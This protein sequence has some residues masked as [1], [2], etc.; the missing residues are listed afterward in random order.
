LD[1]EPFD[2]NWPEWWTIPGINM[3]LAEECKTLKKL[4]NSGE[5]EMELRALCAQQL[6]NSSSDKKSPI[7]RARVAAIGPSGIFLRAVLD[8]K[9]DTVVDVPIR[10]VSGEQ[11]T[12]E[13][14]RESVLTIMDSV[15]YPVPSLPLEDISVPVEDVVV[16]ASSEEDT[17]G[18]SQEE[19]SVVVK[20]FKEAMS[21]GEE[22][23]TLS[24]EAIK[25]RRRQ[26]K[27]SDVE[28]KLAAKYAAIED[29]GERAYTI[30]KDLA[31]I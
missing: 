7:Q 16:T 28:A 5:F 21:A 31:M 29:I 12:A 23:P 13:D 20:Q 24:A 27:S 1:A 17:E 25:D 3:M 26:P 10:F 9:H 22:K 2:V 11:T 6:Q 15:E 30:L 18:V 8:R 19:Q 14:L 4:L